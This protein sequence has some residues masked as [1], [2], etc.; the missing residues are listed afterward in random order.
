MSS[1]GYYYGADS[2]N[3]LKG[4]GYSQ[5]QA[6]C[7]SGIDSGT[8]CDSLQVEAHSATTFS[9]LSLTTGRPVP[10]DLILPPG[11]GIDV[12]NR[13]SGITIDDED[14]DVER[15]CGS[16]IKIQQPPVVPMDTEP[17]KMNLT[18][19]SR[20]PPALAK[21]VA[22][23]HAPR[24]P[25]RTV[26]PSAF[27]ISSGS[28]GVKTVAAPQRTQSPRSVFIQK[29]PSPST[30]PTTHTTAADPF[31]ENRGPF[32]LPPMR[33][34]SPLTC[35]NFSSLNPERVPSDGVSIDI[36]QL[37]EY[38]SFFLPDNKDGDT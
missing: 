8:F 38:M 32:S 15:D 10:P 28:H 6:R 16:T 27:T 3:D 34:T 30:H 25:R 4:M 1:S 26:T 2:S 33:S 23:R 12:E 9:G 20:S 29:H 24:L 18:A 11:G 37:R 19:P 7:D 14:D 36:Y 31:K 35:N 5:H 21:P 17:V 13:D 22:K